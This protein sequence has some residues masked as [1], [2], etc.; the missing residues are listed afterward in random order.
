[1]SEPYI[2]KMPQLSDT[3]SEGV[4][5][6]WEKNIGDKVE[7]GDIVATVETDKAIM[8]VEV[9]REGYLSGPIAEPDSVIPVGEVIAYLVASKAEV[10]SEASAPVA[11]ST[12]AKATVAEAAPVEVVVADEVPGDA[13]MVKMP[14]LSDTMT[15]GVMVSWEK[16]VGDKVERGDVIAQVETDKAIMDVEVFQEGYLSGPMAEID[17]VIPVGEAIAYLVADSKAVLDS[18]KTVTAAETPA[19]AVKPKSSP[20]GTA[21]AKTHIP[22]QPHGAT[23]APRPTRKNATPYARQLAGA[24][25]IDLNSIPGTGPDGAVI[26]ADVLNSNVQKTSTRRIFQVAGEGRAMS[27]MEKAVSHNIDRKSTRLNSSHTDISRMP[28]SA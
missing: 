17:S 15:E 4:V 6:S 23:P 7:R 19:P 16:S 12:S 21:Q 3:M 10:Q 25:G 1:M 9:F 26:A 22:A 20:A 14:Q 13:R 28:S 27:S 5:V 24:H 2:I 18:K 11:A 8:D